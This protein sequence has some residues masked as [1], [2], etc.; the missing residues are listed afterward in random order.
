VISGSEDRT[1]KVWDIR[2]GGA[3]FNLD[4]GVN[5]VKDV[6][7]LHGGNILATAG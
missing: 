6:I 2:T 5:H 3:V 7:C 4:H 1:V